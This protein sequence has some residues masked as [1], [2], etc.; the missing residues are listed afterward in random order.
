MD[1]TGLIITVVTAWETCV[2][3]FEIIDSGKKYGMDYE[4]LRVKLEVERI[5]LLAWGE[6]VGLSGVEQGKPSP[7]ARLNREDVRVVV[8]RLLGCIQHVFEHSDQLQ[9]I[10]GLRPVHPTIVDPQEPPSQSQLILGPIFKRAYES[11]RRSAKYRQRTTPLIRKTIWAVHDKKK[12]QT[13]IAEI[14]DFNDGLEALFPD[15]SSQTAYL[16]RTDIDQSVEIRDLQILQE[17]TA[18]DHEEISETASMRLQTLGTIDTI[19]Q[20]TALTM[21]GE[22]DDE[23]RDATGSDN[24]LTKESEIATLDKYV[25]KKNEGALTLSLIKPQRLSA[26]VT[27]HVNWDGEQ[28]D[29]CWDDREIGFV[30]LWHPSFGN[31]FSCKYNSQR[32]LTESIALYRGHTVTNSLTEE[33]DI[34]LDVE[35]SG[36]Y[37]SIHPGTVT[38]EGF[39][40][41]CKDYEEN[42]GK[43]REKTILPVVNHSDM[44]SLPAKK[45]LRRLDELRR[46]GGKFGWN[47]TQGKADVRE[48]TGNM[49]WVQQYSVRNF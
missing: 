40:M 22:D 14:K 23:E 13:L 33:N 19:S 41:E 10:Y 48:F 20:P 18:D 46:G 35:S 43:P 16:I 8:L 37:E 5:R 28:R 25:R 11:L 45:L 2:Q 21:T 7:D 4:I 32:S 29:A 27:A 38:V 39:G 1:V 49:G 31:G 26:K 3:V 47:P 44:P 12:F 30:K 6:A 24:V 36:R 34:L 17:A 15:L 9:D 42:F